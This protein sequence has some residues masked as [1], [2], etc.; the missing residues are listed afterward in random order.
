MEGQLGQIRLAAIEDQI[1]HTV[2]EARRLEAVFMRVR[3][4]WELVKTARDMNGQL[5]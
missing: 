4:N 2:F 1:V 5:E 3:E